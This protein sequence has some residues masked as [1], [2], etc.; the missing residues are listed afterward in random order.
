MHNFLLLCRRTSGTQHG[1]TSP[2][3]GALDLGSVIRSGSTFFPVRMEGARPLLAVDIQLSKARVPIRPSMDM[4]AI[5]KTSKI[6]DMAWKQI[7]LYLNLQIVQILKDMGAT[8]AEKKDRIWGF[9]ELLQCC[10][11]C[12]AVRTGSL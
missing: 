7:S 3:W 2:R 11:L 5:P 4:K 9:E 12:V 6:S 8:V 1:V 10:D